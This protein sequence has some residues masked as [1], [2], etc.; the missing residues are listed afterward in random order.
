MPTTIE[1]FDPSQ[2]L[3]PVQFPQDERTGALKLAPS[4]TV[5]KGQALAI[6]TADTLGYPLSPGTS[7]TDGTQNFVGFAKYSCVT[8][9]N[10][11]VY[12]VTSP[13]TATPN[14]RMGPYDTVPICEEGVF[15]PLDLSTVA[16]PT[17]GVTTL[18]STGTVTAADVFTVTAIMGDL[19][20]RTVSYTA[21]TSDTATIVF[22]ALRA[23]WNANPDLVRLGTVSGTSTFIVT[24]ASGAAIN[25]TAAAA[26]SIIGT[27]AGT[28][29]VSNTATTAQTG[30][31]IA[32]IQAGRPGAH[33]LS[34]GFWR[35]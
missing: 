28:D 3:Q 18:A 6:K 33:I 11:K 2:I 29:T 16:T 27:V 22:T 19:T 4:I 25:V 21:V 12:F 17:A 26:F 13:L 14:V 20:T 10:S 9:A 8:D 7:T 35:I 5:L 24:S 23:A 31:N 1:I 15:D 34:N 30:H 32:D